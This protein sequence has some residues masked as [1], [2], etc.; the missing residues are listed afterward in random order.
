M[1]KLL[2]L[3]FLII[4]C[5]IQA[6]ELPT[7]PANGFIFTIGSKFTIKLFAVDSINYYY[8]VIAFEKFD[9]TVDTWNNDDLF[10]AVGQDS[11]ITFYFCL[12]THGVNEK[13]KQVNMQ[14]LLIMKNYSKM[15][16]NYS[17]DIQRIENGK[18]ESTSNAGTFPGAEGM[19]MWP[20]MI[21]T[22]GL[23]EFR[24]YRH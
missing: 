11:T 9:K 8:S 20:Y 12:G 18:F 4:S 10:N 17:S 24:N 3:S 16:L 15:A 5:L 14:V 1:K 22:I 6:Q 19:E 7:K 21:Y 2:L 23:K 13:E